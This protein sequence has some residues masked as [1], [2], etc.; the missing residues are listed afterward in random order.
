M[1]VKPLVECQIPSHITR[2]G[3]G[4]LDLVVLDVRWMEEKDEVTGPQ[5]P[6]EHL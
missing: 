6:N 1:V 2:C 5:S 3:R 4:H